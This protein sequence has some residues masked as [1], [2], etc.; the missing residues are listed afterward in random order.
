MYI[1]FFF[2]LILWGCGQRWICGIG[3]QQTAKLSAAWAFTIT[4][5]GWHEKWLI[6][7]YFN[8]LTCVT[9]LM[10]K[11][12]KISNRLCL[13]LFLYH[14][15]ESKTKRGGGHS[16]DLLSNLSCLSTHLSSWLRC[17]LKREHL[18]PH[19][20]LSIPVPGG[21]DWMVVPGLEPETTYQFSVLAQN[22]L[23]TGPFSEV[24]TVNT[25]GEYGQSCLT[26]TK[27]G[28]QLKWAESLLLG[29]EIIQK[30]CYIC[31]FSIFKYFSDSVWFIY[32][33]L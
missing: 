25:L 4:C 26:G 24:V 22:K 3:K 18:G 9:K 32:I 23:G 12:K 33:N 30:L 21:H 7:L 8:L 29:T 31:V 15:H 1:F 17:R 28:M 19:D 10:L 6:M 20:W 13:K 27:G 16:H 11:K 2:F 14:Q 5:C